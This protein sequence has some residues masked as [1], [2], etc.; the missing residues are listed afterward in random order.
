VPK[1]EENRNFESISSARFNNIPETITSTRYTRCGTNCS[2][3]NRQ[4]RGLHCLSSEDN[5]A[6]GSAIVIENET[7]SEEEIAYMHARKE[8]KS[9][10]STTKKK[11]DK[12]SRNTEDARD[13]FYQ[14]T[15]RGGKS[16]RRSKN[17]IFTPEDDLPF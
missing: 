4:E 16:N 12:Y 7:I 6:K 10:K 13:I 11:T 14:D 17:Y 5:S 15:N 9:N 8:S 1:K 2:V 3:C